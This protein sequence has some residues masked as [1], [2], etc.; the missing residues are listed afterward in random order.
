MPPASPA[1]ADNEFDREVRAHQQRLAD[2]IKA[3]HRLLNLVGE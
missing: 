1:V 2:E 3:E